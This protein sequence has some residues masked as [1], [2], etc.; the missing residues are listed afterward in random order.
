MPAV[1]DGVVHLHRQRH[2]R[3][4]A[5]L[6]KAADGK[7]R[8]QVAVPLLQMQMKGGKARPRDAGDVEEVAPFVRF[9]GRL[10]RAAVCLPVGEVVPIK[11][12]EVFIKPR[13]YV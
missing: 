5:R 1:A 11:D 8:R 9:G 7:Q 3:P 2:G 12:V 6:R 10:R 13:S 4:A